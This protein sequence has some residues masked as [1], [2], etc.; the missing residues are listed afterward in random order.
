MRFL[1]LF[2]FVASLK[3]YNLKQDQN[4]RIPAEWEEQEAVWVG[5]DQNEKDKCGISCNWCLHYTYHMYA[6][7]FL[8]IL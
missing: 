7:S 5:W 3:G 1:I 4:F 8:N 6:S 2:L